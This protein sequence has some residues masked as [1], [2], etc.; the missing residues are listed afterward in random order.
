MASSLDRLSRALG[1]P[2]AVV[3][4][5]VFDRWS[6]IVGPALAAHCRPL[7]LRGDA[8]VVAADDPAW[9]SQLR[10]CS[11]DVLGRLEGLVSGPVPSRLVVRVRPPAVSAEGPM[12]ES[13]GSQP[14]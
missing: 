9:G 5:A 10:Y 2:R 13:E 6:E 14:G 3:V 8:V 4:Q 12:V 7:S 1:A 11:A